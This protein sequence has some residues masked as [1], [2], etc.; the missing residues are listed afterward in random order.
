MASNIKDEAVHR[1]ARR[2]AVLTGKSLTAA[3][4]DALAARLAEVEHEH[5]ETAGDR[6]A[7]A[8]LQAAR[9]VRAALGAG[10]HSADHAALQGDDGLP[11]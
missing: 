2:L 7:D 11:Q 3:V 4:R 1:D 8:I 10:G 5:A 6:S 9:G